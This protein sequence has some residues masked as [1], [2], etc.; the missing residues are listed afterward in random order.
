M[1][2]VEKWYTK[3]LDQGET[4]HI[5][6]HMVKNSYDVKT[7]DVKIHELKENPSDLKLLYAIMSMIYEQQVDLA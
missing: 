1:S 3:E 6:K 2:E 5:T 7:L 4:M